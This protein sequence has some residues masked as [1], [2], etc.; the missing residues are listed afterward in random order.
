MEE[1]QK[2]FLRGFIFTIEVNVFFVE[3]I[4]ENFACHPQKYPI[5]KVSSIKVNGG[6]KAEITSN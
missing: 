1:A 2:S 3:I 6:V 4:F 5:T